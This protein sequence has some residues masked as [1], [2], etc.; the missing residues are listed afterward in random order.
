MAKKGISLIAYCGLYCG[1]CFIRIG[2]IA[3]LA[4]KLS[5]ELKKVEFEKH[6]KGLSKLIKEFKPLSH[7]EKFYKALCSLDSL[8][9]EKTCKQ[10]GGTTSCRIRECCISKGIDGCWICNEFEHCKKLAWLE[11]VNG[12]ANLKNLR[13]IRK[14]GIRKF[15]TGKKCWSYK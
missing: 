5:N 14:E 13:K 7:Y 2:K 3:N 6:A 4:K 8:Q 15:L 11:P 10:G 1:D 12:D 9:C